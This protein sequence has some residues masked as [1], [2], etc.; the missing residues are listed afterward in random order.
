MYAYV[1]KDF[2]TENGIFVSS[3]SANF[4][5]NFA[6]DPEFCPFFCHPKMRP[7]MGV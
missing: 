2:A 3:E 6:T 4:V 1:L 5:K 7:L